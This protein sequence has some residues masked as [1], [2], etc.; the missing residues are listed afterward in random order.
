MFFHILLG[1]FTAFFALDFVLIHLA[2]AVS[3]ILKG[4]KV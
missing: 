3:A 4:K 2:A 1:F